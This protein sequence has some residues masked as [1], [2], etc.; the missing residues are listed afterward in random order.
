MHSLPAT[1]QTHTRLC[2]AVAVLTYSACDKQHGACD[3]QVSGNRNGMSDLLPCVL[4]WAPSSVPCTLSLSTRGLAQEEIVALTSRGAVGEAPQSVLGSDSSEAGSDAGTQTE[5]C[6][7]PA[8][9]AQAFGHKSVW[10]WNRQPAP[11]ARPLCHHF[12]GCQHLVQRIDAA[13]HG[14]WQ[15][16][17][18]RAAY[19]QTVSALAG[20]CRQYPLKGDGPWR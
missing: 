14:L 16:S 4:Q 13:E 2:A 5:V 8:P 6:F 9:L 20:L 11:R 10:L 1:L 17:G 18:A 12:V 15:R 3:S 7:C 19:W